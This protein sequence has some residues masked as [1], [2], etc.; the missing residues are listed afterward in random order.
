[1]LNPLTAISPI[2]GRYRNKV[3]NLARY[4]S[5]AALMRYRVR[6]E[7]EWF[8]FLCNTL[9]LK[10]TKVLNVKEQKLMRDLYEA[11]SEKSAQRIKDIESTTNHDVKAVEYFIKEKLTR[12][13]LAAYLE[14][15]HFG[16][17]SEDINNL[18]YGLIIHEFGNEEF[19]VVFSALIKKIRDFARKYAS[20]PMLSH[21]HGQ[22]ASPTTVGKEFMNV[23]SR[24][25][26]QYRLLDEQKVL[27]KMNGATGNF[28][29]HVIAYPEI[30]WIKA[31]AKFISSLGLVQ[32]IYTTQIEPHDFI[33]EICDCVKRINTILIDFDR[34][35]WMYISMDYFKQKAIKGE[36]GSSAMPH[37]INPIYF[38]NSE[39]NL[40]V[41][42]ALF[43]HFSE[44]LPVSRLQRD[45][46][47]S[48]VFRNFGYAFSLTILAYKSTL[49]ALD[50]IEVNKK[51]IQED[52]DANWEVLAEAVQT[53]LRKYKVSCAYEK[54]KE[55]TRGQK[56]TPEAYKKFV[57]DFNLPQAEKSKLLKLAPTNYIG[58]AKK[59]V[60]L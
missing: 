2:D 18:S 32:N 1:M 19:L 51:V 23:V 42:N 8:I 56:I 48:T 26:R 3:E 21:T 20:I 5:E 12:T 4:F 36:V 7:V 38:E 60:E 27:G 17:T 25:E 50:R 40:G 13:S 39:G 54:L 44:K 31:S 35:M 53:V 16:C 37:K 33:A 30:D 28:N 45:L 47:D 10:G 52:L 6:I 57:S 11:F 46:T 34:D 9:R 29:A 22:S 14:F 41:A 58:L 55:L 49:T 24:L 59:L 43:T 15:V